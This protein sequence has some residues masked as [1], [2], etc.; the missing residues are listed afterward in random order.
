MSTIQNSS[1]ICTTLI[2]RDEQM[3]LLTEL[4]T[5]ATN[6]QSRLARI[7]GEAGVGKSR[8]VAEIKSNASQH[9]FGV[10]QGRCFEQD[11][12]FPYAPV[13]DLL[14]ACL[15]GHSPVALGGLFGATAAELVKLL[16]ELATLLPNLTPTPTGDPE[17]EKRRL[18][19]ALTHFLQQLTTTG[20]SQP[21]QPLLVIF[22]DLH[23][24]DDASLEWLLYLARQLR[25]QPILV[26][27]TY[28]HDEIQPGLN[29]LLAA[30][31]RMPFVSEF[32]LSPLARSDVDAMLR[33][34]F[35]LAHPPRAEFLDEIYALT[36][37][38]PFFI[39]EVLK[40]LITAGDIYQVS[41]EWTRKPLRELHIP[42]TVQVAV[43]QRTRQLS[44]ATQHLL[45]LA[46][47]AGQRFNFVVLQA[48]TQQAEDQ[49]LQQVKELIAAQLVVEESDETFAFRHALT[50]QA[51]Y[52]ALLGRE[53]KTLHRT[54]AEALERCYADSL[55]LYASE[56]AY[57]FYE[58]G[59]WAAALTWA[60]RAGEQAE[61][62]YAYGEALRHYT[63]ARTCAEKLGQS[64]LMTALDRTIGHVHYARNQF[65][66]ALEFYGRAL[67]NTTDPA[68]CAA[69]KAQ[70]GAAYAN[71][72]DER[73]QAFLHAALNE[74]DPVTQARQVALATFWLGRS[75]HYLGQYT[76]ALPYLER[77]RQLSEPLDDTP[78]L[79]YVYASLAITLMLSAHFEQGAAWAH[80]CVALGKAKQYL[81]ALVVGYYDLSVHAQ[82]VGRWRDARDFAEQ[83][84]R[85]TQQG[86]WPTE[87]TWLTL[88]YARAVYQ[89]E[90]LALGMQSARAGLALAAELG[91]NRSLVRAHEILALYETALGNEEAAFVEGETAVRTADTLMEVSLR[92]WS[93]MALAG[94]HMQREEWRL[95]VEL[96]EQCAVLLANSENRI[97]RMELGALLAGAYSAH[98]RL[99]EAGQ[100]IDEM[101]T[102]TQATGMRHY[103]AVAWRVQGQIC[104]AQGQ[105][106]KGLAAFDQAIAI[107]TELGSN[108]E[109]AHVRYQRGVL[110]HTRHDLPSAQ[111]DWT[112]ARTLCE[113][114]GAQA[115][116]WRTHAALGQLAHAQQ[117]AGEA[118]HEFAAARAIV[119][120]LAADMH[121]ES[122]RQNLWQRAAALLPAEPSALSRRAV[123]TAFGGLTARERE[124]AALIAQGK[125]NREI[126]AALVV[127]ER[128][129]TTH[130]TNIFTKLSFTSR[131]QIATWAG[132]TGL[133]RTA[134]KS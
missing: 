66:Q 120:K 119:A 31:D 36:E 87:Q 71:I 33:A 80:Q 75:Y 20:E 89:Q 3:A 51:I 40:S 123:K 122:F 67:Q 70:I 116:L 91:E 83:G 100:L 134:I 68:E 22:E 35:K 63:C 42:R 61:R 106:D 127:S 25:T 97:L 94:L 54:L 57:H 77:A 1:V 125:S 103:E 111:A 38:N 46:A 8:L 30:L 95:A 48:I 15:A 81:P 88:C 112:S 124:V 73:S 32:V 10:V 110:H 39:E 26:V 44:Q 101:L 29:Q 50:R 126:A 52:S 45:T 72:A 76:Q 131:A 34:I 65:S 107:C 99:A 115:L 118:E 41:G 90:H 43:E 2:R 58:A 133:I 17:Q 4:M 105:L 114:M 104:A 7:A 6:G 82:Y 69:L 60:Q 98:G 108:L 128:T 130:I 13:I 132:E 62:L 49:L 5:L 84:R 64:D 93:R 117:R 109:L 37:G 28:R 9:G 16:P 11:R 113:Q 24:A 129:V 78:L 74:L 56:I 92:C 53:R 85:L 27:L 23:W 55:D 14:R 18:F 96:Y 79:R 86:D 121:D 102:E 47:V 21:R 19:Q 59:L 12:S